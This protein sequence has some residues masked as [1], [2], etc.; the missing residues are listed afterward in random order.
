MTPINDDF[1]KE[2]KNDVWKGFSLPELLTLGSA[3]ALM[4]GIM[5]FLVFGLDIDVTISLLVAMLPAVPVLMITFGKNQEGD[6]FWEV[7][8][9][10]RYQNATR[11]L[12]Y[13]CGEYEGACLQLDQLKKHAGTVENMKTD[14]QKSE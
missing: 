3:L 5:F 8:Q 6:S 14:N 11:I 1:E 10:K 13:E 12:S 7:Y 2:Y 4:V 9:Q